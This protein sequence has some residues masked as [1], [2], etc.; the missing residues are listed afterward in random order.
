MNRYALVIALASIAASGQVFADDIT[1]DNT[2]FTSTA[3]RAQVRSEL[4]QF[5]AAGVNTLADDYQPLQQFRSTKTR[6]EVTAEF[7]RSRD[8]VAAFTGED[9]GSFYLSQQKGRAVPAATLAG[10]PV[11]AQ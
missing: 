4:Q 1:I 11:N 6:A 10:Q 2:P 7:L 3:T 5:R 9:S 8:A